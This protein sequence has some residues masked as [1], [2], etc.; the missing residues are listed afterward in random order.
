MCV[1]ACVCVS[2]LYACRCVREKKFYLKLSS[3]ENLVLKNRYFKDD[4]TLLDG[5]V[6]VRQG[7]SR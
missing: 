4:L 2:V 7:H 3:L 5:I 1:F 6:S